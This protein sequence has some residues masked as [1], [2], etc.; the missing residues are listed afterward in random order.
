LEENGYVVYKDVATKEEREKGM[1]HV[2]FSF[3][4]KAESLLWE[5]LAQFG[6][7][8]NDISTWD[9][10]DPFHKGILPG[11]GIGQS[12]FLWFCRGLPKVKQIYAGIWETEELLTSFDGCCKDSFLTKIDSFRCTQAF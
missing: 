1:C 3:D 9:W 8:K 7:D 11:N 4:C 10:V 2:C 12:A 5:Y 6:V